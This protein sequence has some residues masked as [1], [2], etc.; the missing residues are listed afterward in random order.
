MFGDGYQDGY[1]A[2]LLAVKELM[3]NADGRTEAYEQ[4]ML[5]LLEELV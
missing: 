4:T 5:F 3:T 2:A 1:R